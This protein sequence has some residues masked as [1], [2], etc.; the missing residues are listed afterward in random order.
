M[1]K[2]TTSILV[3]DQFIDQDNISAIKREG[4]GTRISL[5][6]GNDIVVPVA[7]EKISALLP[8]LKN[9]KA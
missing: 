6:Q 3:G 4:K 8:G 9:D 1:S 2:I 7:Y 5:L